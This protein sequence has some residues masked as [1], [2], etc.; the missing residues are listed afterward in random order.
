MK[1]TIS[2][3]IKREKAK[4]DDVEQHIKYH[5]DIISEIL[6]DYSEGRP[7]PY[8][9]FKSRIRELSNDLSLKGLEGIPSE[10]N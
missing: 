5:L 6:F 4:F 10:H 7:E 2:D 9:N 8:K 1:E 3:T